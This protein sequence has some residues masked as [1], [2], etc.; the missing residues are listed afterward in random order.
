MDDTAGLLVHELDQRFD[1]ADKP[2]GCRIGFDCLGGLVQNPAQENTQND[3]IE[4][5]IYIDD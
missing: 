5:G 1:G 4:D 3:R 2:I